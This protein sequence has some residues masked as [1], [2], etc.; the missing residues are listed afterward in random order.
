MLGSAVAAAP[1]GHSPFLTDGT[2]FSLYR[3]MS[4]MHRIVLAK[5]F[6]I[7][8]Y[9]PDKVLMVCCVLG[10]VIGPETQSRIKG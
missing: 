10:N 9:I 1:R 8:K 4:P 7:M 5:T 3:E 6:V 2:M